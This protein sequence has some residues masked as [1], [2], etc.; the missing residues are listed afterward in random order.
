MSNTND[1][2]IYL[3]T[4]GKFVD[5]SKLPTAQQNDLKRKW[6]L[7]GKAKSF[8]QFVA[9]YSQTEE[10]GKQF[11]Q[12]KS[13]LTAFIDKKFGL[14]VL[15]NQGEDIPN[16]QPKKILGMTPL[17]FGVVS[18]VFVGVLLTVFIILSKTPSVVKK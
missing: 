18:V 1:N 13:I 11:D 6:D 10:G 7:S 4:M 3:P 5:I 14:D 12:L 15:A 17:Q 8:K 2:L 9:D 16:E